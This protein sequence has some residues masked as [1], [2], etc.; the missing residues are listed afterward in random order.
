MKELDRCKISEFGRKEM[1]LHETR[2]LNGFYF[3]IENEQLISNCYKREDRKATREEI[4]MWE[5]FLSK[6]P[7]Y[8]IFSCYDEVCENGVFNRQPISNPPTQQDGFWILD[9]FGLNFMFKKTG[10]KK[11]YFIYDSAVFL[12]NNE[13]EELKKT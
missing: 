4:E 8:P 13:V 3:K 11:Y 10:Q 9:S 1:K 6:T 5:K 2:I 12:S 7:D